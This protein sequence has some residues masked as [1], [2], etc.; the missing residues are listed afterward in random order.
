VFKDLEQMGHALYNGNFAITS[1]T[2][3]T[4]FINPIVKQ[5]TEQKFKLAWKKTGFFD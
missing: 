3:P 1:M 4:P 2:V 5:T